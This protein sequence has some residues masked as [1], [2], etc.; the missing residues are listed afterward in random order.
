VRGVNPSLAA[1]SYH[2]N[3]LPIIPAAI[4]LRMLA[5]FM[6]PLRSMLLGLAQVFYRMTA[7]RFLRDLG[8]AATLWPIDGSL[9]TARAEAILHGDPA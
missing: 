9:P 6:F 3:K 7:F 2:S 4:N 8:I 1:L 5:D